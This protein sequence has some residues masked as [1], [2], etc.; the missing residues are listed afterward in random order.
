MGKASLFPFHEF[1]GADTG[2]DRKSEIA[3]EYAIDLRLKSPTTSTFWIHANN[4]SSFRRDYL[5]I[6]EEADLPQVTLKDIERWLTS[7]D[8][9][10]W[11]IVVDDITADKEV[12]Q[13]L[14]LIPKCP[15]GSVIFTTRDRDVALE[16]PHTHNIVEVEAPDPVNAK[17]MLLSYLC[18]EEFTEN[19]IPA[20]ME[21]LQ[22]LEYLPLAISH[23]GAFMYANRVSLT[24]YCQLYNMNGEI[25]KLEL[26]A[27]RDI[28]KIVPPRRFALKGRIDSL[29][30]DR[31]L[32]I[33]FEH[34]KQHNPGAIKLL[35]LMACLDNSKIPH[36]LL[37]PTDQATIDLQFEKD[38]GILKANSLIQ[39][40]DDENSSVHNL[41]HLT[42]REWLREHNLFRQK[43]REAFGIVSERFPV[44][45]SDYL[46]IG[47]S[48][49]PHAEALL[50][51]IS[52]KSCDDKKVSSKI[53]RDASDYLKKSDMESL[54]RAELAHRCSRHL[55]V[56]GAYG[57]A[58]RLAETAVTFSKSVDEGSRSTVWTMRSNLATVL[59]YQ[60]HSEEARGIDE[61]VLK[62][63][64]VT[65][66]RDH[67]DTL[68]GLNNLGLTMYDLGHYQEAESMHR[69][70]FSARKRVLGDEH[71]DT[72]SSMN[73]LVMSLQKQGQLQE[74]RTLGE[75]L[76]RLK[77]KVL[78]PDH[79][80]TLLSVNNLG[81]VL[82]QQ[83]LFAEAREKF[84][85]V[86][87][88]RKKVL[89]PTHPLTISSLNNIC[90]ILQGESNFEA[91]EATMRELLH[92]NEKVLG[93]THPNT[94]ITLRNLSTVLGSLKRFDEA[95][96]LCREA[97]ARHQETLGPEHPE[98]LS[99]AQ[100]LKYLTDT[101]AIELEEVQTLVGSFSFGKCISNS[102]N[103]VL[104][105][106][107]F[108]TY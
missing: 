62:I 46:A 28:T 48:Y 32:K 50:R 77:R 56:R 99:T 94:I 19:E 9:G 52:N 83:E 70:A 93:A 108:R 80:D 5:S 88:K 74:A 69:Q 12:H 90:C 103:M 36:S 91:A 87:E 86:W 7:K 33:S 26:L 61:E 34:V 75:E 92:A 55:Q 15:N 106:H 42:L 54:N 41:V 57:Q 101:H 40:H 17:T 2:C 78:G 10:E 23:M 27:D 3:F 67:Q 71:K 65:L 105:K 1:D 72:L 31:T 38:L 107:G 25:S 89:G 102:L 84:T 29:P 43:A 96:G 35:C 59:R 18:K 22:S 95:E 39:K 98:T 13:M 82:H 16:L 79:F 47:D 44:R 68:A 11:L 58:R 64:R 24:R 6:G 8:V 60:G 53:E 20:A 76:V 85:E 66:G 49:L 81:I 104:S 14:N 100:T 73:N 63:R 97:L 45:D 21:I 4:I 51:D 37:R 30:V